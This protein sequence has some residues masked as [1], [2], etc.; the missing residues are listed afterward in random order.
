[1]ISWHNRSTDEF[2]EALLSLKTMEE[3]YAFLDD[4][5]T[6]REVLDISQRLS[7]A[8]MLAEGI[9]YAVISKETGASTATISRVSKCYEYG[10]GGYK[11]VIERCKEAK[12]ND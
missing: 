10:S 2:C 11:T 4:V 3:C 1:M 6:I 8:K 12:N 7:V 5:C 9:S